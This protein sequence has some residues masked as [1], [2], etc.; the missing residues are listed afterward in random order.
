MVSGRVEN[1]VAAE[2]TY[3]SR[4]SADEQGNGSEECQRLNVMHIGVVGD[5]PGGIAQ[6]VGE[7]LS[8]DYRACRT[9]GIRSTLGRASGRRGARILSFVYWMRSFFLVLIERLRQPECV[10]VVHMSQRGSFIREG[11]LVAFS[12]LLGIPTAIHLHGSSFPEFS[13]KFP[14]FTRNV[15]KLAGTVFVLTEETEQVC[16][17]LLSEHQSIKIVPVR[18]AVKVPDLPTVKASSVLFAG[19]VGERKGAD[20]LI[21]AWEK[22]R[23]K[24]PGWR[25][26]VVGP[27]GHGF[28]PD[29]S[30]QTIEYTGPLPRQD[31]LKLAA[32]S[33]IAVL[34]SRDEA[35]PMF[36]L[37]SMA[38]GCAVISTPVGQIEE[39]L[40]GVGTIVP[41]GD[42]ATLADAIARLGQDEDARSI[43]ASLGR[44][45][46]VEKYSDRRVASDLE[47]AWTELAE[48]K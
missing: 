19:E 40:D 24:L 5:I 22:A 38:N 10:S 33:A 11:A 32:Q 9:T 31:V 18:N 2:A 29:Y 27:I 23:D 1:P 43:S 44:T 46:I 21:A 41:V 48:R 15:L 39:L 17:D 20:T 12:R 13:R 14:Q 16:T 28:A 34:P 4:D 25:L 8:W 30:D 35:L 3:P 47:R 26:I 7:Y 37:E 6:V 42:V 45:R 36:L